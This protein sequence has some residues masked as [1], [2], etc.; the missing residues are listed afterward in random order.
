M[1][2]IHNI[3]YKLGY[4]PENL[5]KINTSLIKK[6]KL[7]KIMILQTYDK[8]NNLTLYNKWY[9]NNTHKNIPY[10]FRVYFN[11]ESLAFWLMNEG[12]ISNK[13]LYVSVKQF[14]K[15]EINNLIR[16]L[17][18]RFKLEKIFV[19]NNFLEFNSNNIIKI[20]QNIKSYIFPSM[21]FKFMI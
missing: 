14:N 2:H 5:P 20:K 6:G 11:E 16:F 7:N 8:N 19:N 15:K 18:N 13:N 21:K 1:K 9:L 10:D 12:I 4:C 17:E 3:F